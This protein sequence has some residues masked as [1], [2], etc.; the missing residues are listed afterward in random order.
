[1]GVFR[2]GRKCCGN[3]LFWL[4][5]FHHLPT[6]ILP[7][8]IPKVNDLC[9]SEEA[10]LKLDPLELFKG[11]FYSVKVD[12]LFL[13]WI[14]THIVFKKMAVVEEEGTVRM[15]DYTFLFTPK[16]CHVTPSLFFHSISTLGSC[17]L[18]LCVTEAPI[19]F[20]CQATNSAL[21][22]K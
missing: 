11:F 17:V 18:L 22:H 8:D 14:N 2:I 6:N 1:M 16:P 9:F 20:L 3:P 4:L 5:I 7:T 15:Q 10:G 19:F 13:D 12:V 21:P